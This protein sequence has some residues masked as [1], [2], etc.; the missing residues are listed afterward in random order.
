MQKCKP[1]TASRPLIFNSSIIE[2]QKVRCALWQVGKPVRASE[3]KKS[4]LELLG[5]ERLGDGRNV[6]AGGVKHRISTLNLVLVEDGKQ[7]TGKRE[8][9]SEG[10][11]GGV[12]D[13][14]QGETPGKVDRADLGVEGLR[15]VDREQ[16]G[17]QT[18]G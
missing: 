12:D 3:R 10:W 14:A 18:G 4:L 8:D 6:L 17:E 7:A 2:D 13:R 15:R 16:V 5:S 9:R 11:V 1:L